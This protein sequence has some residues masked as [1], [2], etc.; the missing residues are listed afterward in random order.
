MTEAVATS[1][2]RATLAFIVEIRQAALSRRHRRALAAVT[3]MDMPRLERWVLHSID[4]ASLIPVARLA[5]DL[6]VDLP[7]LSRAC[8]RLEAEGCVIR[9]EDP[10]DRRRTLVGLSDKAAELMAT[11][12][13]MWPVPYLAAVDGW[14]P[15][16]VSRL[17]DWL[18]VVR[19]RWFVEFGS[20][21]L[22]LEARPSAHRGLS[23]DQVRFEWE[24]RDFVQVAGR[25]DDLSAALSGL[26]EHRPTP[27]EFALMTAVTADPSARILDLAAAEDVDPSLAHRQLRSL[28]TKGLLASASRSRDETT[29]TS[30]TGGETIAY[31]VTP[32]GERL[33]RAVTARR[34]L[35]VPEAPVHLLE[36]GL[37]LDFDE[38]V[39][40]L[41]R[42]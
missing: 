33:L 10:R 27:G 19:D 1:L 39:A 40:N 24:I 15:D 7:R 18:R 16:R 11:W 13:A 12:N 34:L 36:Q 26:D 28:A 25:T 38:F 8:R 4:G 3:G 29:A 23:P 2:R 37:A 42:R 35:A 9:I 22:R 21:V 41:L 31:A 14:C 5:Q 20:G 30:R 6:D 32:A 17:E